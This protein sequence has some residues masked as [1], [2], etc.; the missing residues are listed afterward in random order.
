MGVCDCLQ[1]GQHDCF[2]IFA[3]TK[4]ER[5]AWLDAL[6]AST[7]S[8]DEV[9]CL[10]FAHL[11][12]RLCVCIFSCRVCDQARERGTPLSQVSGRSPA[13]AGRHPLCVCVCVSSVPLSLSLSF[14]L[15]F[16]PC[17]SLRVCVC[18]EPPSLRCSLPQV[19]KKK[20]A[21]TTAKESQTIDLRSVDSSP[22]YTH[23]VRNK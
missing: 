19:L 4:A 20:E 18:N 16:S 6:H 10:S 17:V 12:H 22:K 11:P 21:K 13:F 2:Q 3:E 7:T 8:Q 1:V 23:R 15:S 9:S 5:D 14:T